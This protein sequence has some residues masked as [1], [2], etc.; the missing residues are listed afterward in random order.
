MTNCLTFAVFFTLFAAFSY[1]SLRFSQVNRV[2]MNCYK[3]MFEVSAVS[4]N[5]SGEPIKPYYDKETLRNYVKEYLEPD[6]KKYV[7]D[8]TL[9]ISYSSPIINTLNY[10]AATLNLKANI[11]FLFKYD[12]S[13][14][15]TILG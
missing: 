13:Q 14:T 12:K 5:S 11:N 9:T 15:F 10:R 2:F 4:V 6:I 3:G 1:G 8:Y 7:S